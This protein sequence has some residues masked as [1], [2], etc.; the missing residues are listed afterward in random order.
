VQAVT[1]VVGMQTHRPEQARGYLL[2]SFGRV[3]TEQQDTGK[4]PKKAK[5]QKALEA[6]RE[7]NLGLLLGALR[8][9]FDSWADHLDAAELDRRAWGWYTALRPDVEGGLAGWGAKGKI[10]LSDVLKLRRPGK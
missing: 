1:G 3:V 5:T 4:S 9:V 8:I 2:R 10:K 6:E 7:E